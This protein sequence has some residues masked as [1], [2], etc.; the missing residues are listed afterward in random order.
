[1][2]MKEISE[3]DE[4]DTASMRRS[5]VRNDLRASNRSAIKEDLRQDTNLSLLEPADEALLESDGEDQF[6]HLLVQEEEKKTEDSA[7]LLMAWNS[8]ERNLEK[9]KRAGEAEEARKQQELIKISEA[10]IAE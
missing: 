6:K 9:D 5:A 1:M 2:M 4:D 8:E 7:A 10:A 3:I